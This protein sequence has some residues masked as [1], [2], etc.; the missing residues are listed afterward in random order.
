[1]KGSV[2]ASVPGKLILMGEHAAVYQRPA[3]VTAVGMRSRVEVEAAEQGVMLDLP[4]LELRE[5]LDWPDVETY[6]RAAREAWAEY[7]EA[8]SR[9]GFENV[10]GE[11]PAHLIKVAL[12][13]VAV[14]LGE[15]PP[16]VAV[17]ISSELPI[18]SGFGSSASLAVG[19]VA[20]LLRFLGA[21]QG[22]EQIDRIALEIERRQHGQPSGVDHRT[23]L[24]GGLLWACRGSDGELSVKPLDA[25]S[26]TLS[27]LAVFDS[28]ES[29]ESTGVVVAA[30][31]RRRERQPE[32]FGE[33]LDR[34]ES[35]VREFAALLPD[36]AAPADRL[37][38]LIRDYEACL[39][40]LGVVPEEVRCA[41]RR[42]EAL[43]GAAKISGAGSLTGPG[44]GCLLVYPAPGTEGRVEEALRPF[45]KHRCELGV[46]G[47]RFEEQA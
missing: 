15:V 27:R 39:E 35:D 43:G 28:G 7:A 13:E 12:G 8:P 26:R 21:D 30:V 34:M 10:R 36:D 16:P 40:D 18:G 19:L 17:K 25:R 5:S 2:I 41:I 29:S 46:E 3:V 22:L 1:M 32:R 45:V 4:D 14:V 6:A 11:D 31:S 38:A 33:L 24:V 47:L 20:S 44:A 23:V 37:R 42:V 9:E